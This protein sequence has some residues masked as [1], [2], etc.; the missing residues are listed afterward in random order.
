MFFERPEGGETAILVNIDLDSQWEQEDPEEFRELVRSAALEEADF[1]GGKRHTPDAGYFVG[2]GKLDQL[3]ERVRA[4][5]AGLVLFNHALSPS[6]ERNLESALGCRVMDRTSL[7]L[8][9]FAQRA[10]THE[11]KLQVELAQLRHV[12]S[13]LK[14]GWTH[15][16]RQKGGVNLRGAGEKQIELDQRMI[17]QRIKSIDRS[18]VKVRA[19]REQGRR[20]R[21]RS[22][23]PVVSLV[24]YTNAGKST[25][26][27]TLTEERLYAADKLFATLDSTWRRMS[28]PSYGEA[29][30]A[31]TVGF[32][33]HLPHHLVEAFRATLEET[34]QATLLLHVIDASSDQRDYYIEQVDEVL[35]EIGAGGVPVL[36]VF[37]KIDRLADGQPRIQ[38]DQ[39][40]RPEQVWVSALRGQ[41]MELLRQA[42]TE[43]LGDEFVQRWL[44]LSPEQGRLRSRL[45]ARGAVQDERVDDEG[46]LY[47]DVRLPRPDFDRI[48]LEER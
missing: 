30:L 46:R 22:N 36:Q 32:I 45:Y 3:F 21:K 47:L 20:A 11:G 1:I 27:N 4:T 31:D 19:Q 2:K 10:R 44:T 40:G 9:I 6:Q 41:G 16:D 25:L 29:V 17:R 8:E 15:L 42:L 48:I 39:E 38:R 33:S 14:R 37:N 12:A 18:L 7:I 24:G 26:F 28:L 34:S 35:E 13:R 43:R 23:T 5:G